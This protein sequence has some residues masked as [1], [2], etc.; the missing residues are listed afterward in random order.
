MGVVDMV[1]RREVE[2]T[3]MLNSWFTWAALLVSSKET[4][5]W[6]RLRQAAGDAAIGLGLAQGGA[7]EGLP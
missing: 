1:L 3:R 4:C 5:T 2:H 7:G 6:R